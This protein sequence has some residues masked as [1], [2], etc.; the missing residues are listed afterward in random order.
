MVST[1]LLLLLC[2]MSHQYSAGLLGGGMMTES[3]QWRQAVLQ[4]PWFCHSSQTNWGNAKRSSAART[5]H[6]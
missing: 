3:P 4:Q 2:F 5:T 1:E 6:T